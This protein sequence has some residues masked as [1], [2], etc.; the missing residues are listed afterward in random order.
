MAALK[1]HETGQHK[2]HG[3]KKAGGLWRP[4]DRDLV[5]LSRVLKPQRWGF[6]QTKNMGLNQQQRGFNPEKV[7]LKQQNWSLTYINYVYKW[8][9]TISIS[10]IH[11]PGSKVS[12]GIDSFTAFTDY[13]GRTCSQTFYHTNYHETI[14]HHVQTC[15]ILIARL[16]RAIFF[17]HWQCANSRCGRARI[18]GSCVSRNVFFL[19]GL[20]WGYLRY[21]TRF[22]GGWLMVVLG[23]WYF[24]NIQI[25]LHELGISGLGFNQQQLGIGGI[26]MCLF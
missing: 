26:W 19:F 10:L 20:I 12:G 25:I 4:K 9:L 24:P 2:R 7:G 8:D 17:K 1:D 14:E 16:H 5:K 23:K 18:A 3:E 15:F 22:E 11:E 21:W 13:T 6:H